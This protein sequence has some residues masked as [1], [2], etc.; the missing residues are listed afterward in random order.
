M[1]KRRI[2]RFTSHG[3]VPNKHTG[4]HKL[5]RSFVEAGKYAP[6]GHARER[7]DHREVLI[8][9]VRDVLLNGKREIYH[10]KFHTHDDYGNS[11]NRWSYA[12]SKQGL[13]RRLRVCVSIDETSEKP[14][15]IITVIDLY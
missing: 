8:Q 5:V 14:L 12:F 1:A 7:L 11:I 6:T 15:L 9:E 10:D 2:R 3:F 4:I 13:D